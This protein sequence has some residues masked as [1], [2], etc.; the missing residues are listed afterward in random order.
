MK[1]YVWY[2]EHTLYRFQKSKIAFEH[3][4]LI[5]VKLCWPIWNYFVFYAISY[6]IQYIQDFDN[7]VNY[8]TMYS[9]VVYKE[10]LKAFYTKTN[11]K[12]YNL[13]IKKNNIYYINT[14]TNKN[15]IILAK[16]IEKMKNY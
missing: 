11:K 3:H 5:N 6:F 14:I 9:K 4:Q 15:M 12:E 8:Y 1:R 16:K 7:A 10:F 2:I 13:Q